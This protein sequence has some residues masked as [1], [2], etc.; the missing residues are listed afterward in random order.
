LFFLQENN[1]RKALIPFIGA[2]IIPQATLTALEVPMKTANDL[3]K[4][5]SKT[6]TTTNA[7]TE[8]SK[9]GVAA[10]GVTAGIIGCWAIANMISG[11]INSGGPVNLAISLFKAING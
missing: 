5:H 3:D 7:C 8:I 1:L 11:T 6:V 9:T 2:R 4:S 10:V